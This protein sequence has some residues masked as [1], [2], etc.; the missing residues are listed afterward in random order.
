M[1]MLYLFNYTRYENMLDDLSYLIS[2][3][4]YLSIVDKIEDE[5]IFSSENEE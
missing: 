2:L 4:D 1:T 5:I 3:N